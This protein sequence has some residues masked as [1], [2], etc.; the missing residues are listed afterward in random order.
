MKKY[1]TT[2]AIA[3]LG[4]LGFIGL[5]CETSPETTLMAF[6]WTKLTSV[7][8]LAGAFALHR[9]AKSRKLIVP[10]QG[11]LCFH[12]DGSMTLSWDGT[13]KWFTSVSGCIEFAEAENINIKMSNITHSDNGN[14][15][16]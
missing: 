15:K 3:A 11:H 13:Q 5:A 12:D 8:L 4:I 2:T 14:T 10:S 16:M 7:T 9:Y 1:I 6:V